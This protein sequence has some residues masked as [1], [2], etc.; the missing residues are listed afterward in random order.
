MQASLKDLAPT[1]HDSRPF[2]MCQRIL[3]K[4]HEIIFGDLPPSIGVPYSALRLP[5]QS[6]LTRRKVKYHVEPA[7]IGISVIL[8]GVP[9]LPQL[10]DI[11]GEVAIEQGRIDEEGKEFKSVE[12]TN[13]DL[14]PG[15]S[16]SISTASI[17]D[18]GD[19]HDDDMDESDIREPDRGMSTPNLI[20]PHSHISS[21][22]RRPT[23]PG[24]QTAPAL[25]LHLRGLRQ[26]RLSDDPLGQLD[27]EQ[28][29]SPY[30]S[31]PSISSSRHPPRSASFNLADVILRTYDAPTQM[32]L[33]RGH[34]CRSEVLYFPLVPGL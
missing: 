4:C 3:H 16:P 18:S 23:I 28:I 15:V 29:Q 20:L 30:Q 2:L 26:S 25:P 24:A 19:D 13:D 31:S 27:T 12:S 11:M 5:F 6:R 33:L 21:I 34:Y 9:A 32:H 1:R 8:A 7:I 17:R 10:T 14:V 22:P